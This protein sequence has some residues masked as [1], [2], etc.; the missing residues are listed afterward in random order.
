MKE[1]VKMSTSTVTHTTPTMVIAQVAILVSIGKVEIVC[2]LFLLQVAAN[3]ILTA[4]ALN[5]VK[6]AT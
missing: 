4:H 3:L 2:K 5:V 1:N 6:E